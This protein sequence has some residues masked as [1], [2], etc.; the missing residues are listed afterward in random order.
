M[1]R[2]E[3]I[4][5]EKAGQLM[6]PAPVGRG[7]LI[8]DGKRLP[9]PIAL[10]SVRPTESFGGDRSSTSETGNR[11]YHGDNLS[12]LAH[13]AASGLRNAV[14]LIYIDPPFD[15]NANYMRKI[16]LRNSRSPIL[17]QQV[18]YSDTW[19]GD[20]YLQFMYER[21]LI[22]RDLLADDGS[23]WLHCD[24]RQVHR[25]HLLLE[26]VFGE[27]NYL[28]TIAWRSQVTRGAKVN[29]FYFPFSTQ[30]IEVFAKNRSAPTLWHPQK[31]KLV[32]TRRQATAQFM[33]DEQGFF[34]TSDPGTYSFEKLVELNGQGRLYAPYEGE[35]IVDEADRR[36]YP[37][38]GGN[39]G[40][41]YYLQALDNGRYAVERGVDNLW[42]DIPGLGTTPGE[43]VSYPTQKTE[44]LLR[45]VIAASTDP[46]D[47][48]LDCFMGSGTTL[49]VAQ[50]MGRSW[51]G[52]DANYGSVQTT[53]RR[54]QRLS[55]EKG[56]EEMDGS[57]DRGF[58]IWKLDS[59]EG[60]CLT[61]GEA[62][63][64][65]VEVQIRRLTGEPSTIELVIQGKT[66]PALANRLAEQR[67]L[68]AAPGEIVWQEVVDAVEIDPAYD[69]CCFRP[70]L[71][72]APQK[73]RTQVEGRYELP[74]GEPAAGMESTTIAIRITD[75]LGHETMI[76]RSL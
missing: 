16:R 36:V 34:R 15:S 12:V 21:L 43:D 10:G 2:P 40:V 24:Y 7:L 42:D 26:E 48:V 22:L 67:S 13:L 56:D 50:Q 17:G 1:T 61:G 45:R 57:D 46:G 6:P 55:E 30:Y 58:A 11:I 28:N 76:I 23:I 38:N 5:P 72:D 64:I 14:R 69:G 19:E 62:S 33:E 18:Q 65:Q 3:K 49:A 4:G 20:S 60:D 29:A 59:T 47:M 73:R 63:L 39:I 75:V 51:I 8:W 35:I 9:D 70:T 37:S 53:R 44:A 32:F 66:T 68:S 74:V 52:C 54:L 27:E 25:L 41:K 71:V 31:K